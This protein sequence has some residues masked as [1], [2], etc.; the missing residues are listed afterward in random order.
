MESLQASVFFWLLPVNSSSPEDT[1]IDRI[2][3]VQ[4]K[5]KIYKHL[6]ANMIYSAS[7]FYK[8]L[9]DN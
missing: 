2:R 4:D 1:G 3:A 5:Q 7:I 9:M 8:I 6:F